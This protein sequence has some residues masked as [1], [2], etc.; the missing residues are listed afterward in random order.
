MVTAEKKRVVTAEQEKVVTGAQ[1]AQAGHRPRPWLHQGA[2]AALPRAVQRDRGAERRPALTLGGAE[3]PQGHQVQT[4]KETSENGLLQRS[5]EDRTSALKLR[6]GSR[7][8]AGRLP[9][10]SAHLKARAQVAADGAGPRLTVC[11]FHRGGQNRRKPE[12]GGDKERLS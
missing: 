7:L 8:Q 5:Q 2:R 10:A 9:Q 4:G 1:A 11:R 6:G 3:V 12:W